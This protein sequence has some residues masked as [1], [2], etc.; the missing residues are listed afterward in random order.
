LGCGGG[1][2]GAPAGEGVGGGGA[3]ARGAVG[4]GVALAGWFAAAGAATAACCLGLVVVARVRCRGWRC[5]SLR[6]VALHDGAVRKAKRP[7]PAL[8]EAVQFILMYAM[9]SWMSV[10]LR[11][12]RGFKRMVCAGSFAAGMR[13]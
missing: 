11:E 10:R 1:A 8:R 9:R 5:A 7:L 13:S 4:G 2:A 6:S 12:H 3:D